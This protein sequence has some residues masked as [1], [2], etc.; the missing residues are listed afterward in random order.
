VRRAESHLHLGAA[1]S[2]AHQLGRRQRRN[3]SADRVDTRGADMLAG[4]Q[5]FG[6]EMI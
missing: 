2:T 5:A 6:A 4:R 1:F 3:A